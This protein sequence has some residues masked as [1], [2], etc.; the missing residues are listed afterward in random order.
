M[1]DYQI[2]LSLGVRNGQ[3]RLDEAGA[4]MGGTHR[5][6]YWF[7]EIAPRPAFSGERWRRK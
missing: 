7:C 6:S 4:A 3:Q 1:S 2:A 5:G